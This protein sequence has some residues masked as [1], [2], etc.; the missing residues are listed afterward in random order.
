MT[1]FL[2]KERAVLEKYFPGFDDYLKSFT[3]EK[4]EEETEILINKFRNINGT[5]LLIPKK[6]GG[7]GANIIESLSIQRAIAT[8][9]PSLAI[10]YTMH[11][12]SVASLVEIVQSH[13]DLDSVL[14][15]IVEEKLLLS[16]CFAEGNANN[17]FSPSVSAEDIGEYYIVNGTKKPCTLS[18][19]MDI[20]TG[21]VKLPDGRLGVFTIPKDSQGI[22]VRDFWKHWILKGSETEEIVLTDVKVPKES[23][24]VAGNEEE[25]HPSIVRGLIW[26]ELIV[27]TSY[28]GVCS[29]LIEKVI[30]KGSLPPYEMRNMVSLIEAA[31]NAIEGLAHKFS[32][33]YTENV[34]SEVI[35]VRKSIEDIIKGVASDATRLLGG[36]QFITNKE[37]S[38]QLLVC[39]LLHF[40]PPAKQESFQIMDNFF[41]YPPESVLS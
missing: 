3:F 28:I 19:S 39:Q 17:T 9:S 25:L 18:K 29:S 11:H 2:A 27:S 38:Y 4:R 8:R 40:H 14:K 30:S 31:M 12:F 36:M 16:S 23:M 26:F 41:A 13:G 10:A 7:L 5:S 15:L 1:Q 6:Y 35:F 24:F 33:N 37:I 34:L 20:L 21:S 22:E 32:M